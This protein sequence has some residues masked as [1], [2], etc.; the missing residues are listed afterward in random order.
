MVKL[1]RLTSSSFIFWSLL[2]RG[3]NSSAQ[4]DMAHDRVQRTCTVVV[5]YIPV[6]VGS[7]SGGY[8]S[9]I[10]TSLLLFSIPCF[11]NSISGEKCADAFPLLG[12]LIP[13]P[14]QSRGPRGGERGWN[15]ETLKFSSH[16]WM[17]ERVSQDGIYQERF[18][19]WRSIGNR[20]TGRWSFPFPSFPSQLP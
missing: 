6:V 4:L 10:I 9:R 17:Q 8:A 16:N 13:P 5:F 19:S 7:S 12:F 15:G 2:I 20:M 1:L 14:L 3:R 11:S 18:F